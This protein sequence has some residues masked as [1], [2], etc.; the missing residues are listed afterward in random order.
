MPPLVL[1]LIDSVFAL[2][3][4][5]DERAR[6]SAKDRASA[7]VRA[8]V[9]GPEPDGPAPGGLRVRIHVSTPSA[10]AT[11]VSFHIDLEEQRLL[12]KEVAL[13]ELPLDRSGL[14]R[15]VGELEAWCYA[16]IPL[17]VPANTHA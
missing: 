12:A 9:T 10:P 6:R 16:Q 1:A 2:A 13:A 8:K 5:H 4:H 17:E 11:S 14:A 7:S 3:L 15:L